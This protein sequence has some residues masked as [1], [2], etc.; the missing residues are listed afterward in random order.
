MPDQETRTAFLQAALWHGSLD[1]ANQLLVEHPDLASSDIHT[2]AV[3]GDHVGVT[4][5]LEQDPS[6]VNAKSPPY[7]GVALNYLGLSKYL[8][9]D[10]SRGDGFIRA[11]RAL[12]DA[13]AD[14]NAGFWNKGEH[15]TVLYGAAGVAHHGL[16]TRLRIER[17]ADPNDP[18]V[19]YHTPESR[20]LDALKAVVETGQLTTESM[21][22]MLIRKCDWHDTDGVRY[23]LE[24]GADPTFIGRR[25]LTPLQ[26]ALVRDNDLPIIELLLDHGAD[27]AARHP[28]LTTTS[29]GLAARR[30][31]SDILDLAKRRGVSVELPGVD[32][33][34]AACALGDDEAIRRIAQS[35][36][37]IVRELVSDGGKVLAEFAANG[38]TDGV[39]RLLDLGVPVDLRFREGDGYWGIAQ[40]S[41]ALHVAAW[42]A[43]HEAARLLIERGADVNAKNRKGQTPIQLA[44]KACVD[45]YWT[46][47]RKPDTVAALLAAG[48]ITEGVPDISGYDDVDAL[49]AAHRSRQAR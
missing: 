35:Q 9:L 15:E 14:P 3:L 30:G 45:S 49:L 36:P 27:F 42:R 20:D 41:T 34:L 28:D 12:L 16:L 17:G 8:R 10:S 39:R 37:A 32:G 7:D 26:H 46:E 1:R 44:V 31:R 24:H 18:E 43:S 47:W 22:L 25:G 5:F 13:G 33:L 2:A 48:A 40:E 38:N 21:A 4:R 11:A 23:L 29:L 6:S 19:V